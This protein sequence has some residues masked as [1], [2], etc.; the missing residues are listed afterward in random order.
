MNDDP[1]RAALRH[2]AEQLL[3]SAPQLDTAAVWHRVKRA[4]ARKIERVLYWCGWS[5]RA[6]ITAASVGVAWLAPAAFIG[7]A[8]PLLLVLWL[9]SGMCAPVRVRSHR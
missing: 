6:V 5:L 3:R 2:D 1:I 9:T 8:L 7:T 4:R